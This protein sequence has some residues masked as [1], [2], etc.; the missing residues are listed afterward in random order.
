MADYGYQGTGKC[1]ARARMTG[2]NASWKDLCEVCRNVRGHSTESAIEF[3]ENAKEGAQ[4]ILFLRHCHGKGHRRELGGKKG[5][6][7]VKSAGFV[8]GVVKSAHANAQKLGLGPTKVAHIAANKM[9]TY[10]RMSPKGRRIRH[11]YE[12]ALIEVVLE[13]SQQE[14]GKGAEKKGKKAAKT[15]TKTAVKP[16]ARKEEKASPRTEAKTGNKD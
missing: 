5:G 9:D 15:E 1:T 10:P 8:L 12:T 11:N 3:L 4:A 14:A 16:E 13:E 7:P 6:F 2:V